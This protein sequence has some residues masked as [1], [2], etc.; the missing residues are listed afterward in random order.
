MRLLLAVAGLVIVHTVSASRPPPS[1][2][3]PPHI[4]L[5]GDSSVTDEPPDLPPPLPLLSFPDREGRRVSFGRV[6]PQSVRLARFRQREAFNGRE[7][8]LAKLSAV[9]ASP[10]IL[11]AWELLPEPPHEGVDDCGFA[12]GAPTRVAIRGWTVPR[13]LRTSSRSRRCSI[14]NASARCSR[15]S[16]RTCSGSAG[17]R[18]WIRIA[19]GPAPD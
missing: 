11:V 13:S 12:P 2:A 10:A 4:V 16:N 15:P 14:G 19:C 7:P 17:W 1:A 8:D 3:I 6:Y 5:A 9:A 18:C